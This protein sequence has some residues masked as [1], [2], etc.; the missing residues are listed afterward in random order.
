MLHL[1][2]EITGDGLD[3]LGQFPKQAQFAAVRALTATAK[4]A[5]LALRA[6]VPGVFHL[7]NSWVPQGV[8][9][10]P[11]TMGS[12]SARVGSIDKYMGRHVFGDPKPAAKPLTI[13]GKRSADG[14][15]ASGGL[16]IAPYSGIGSAEKHQVVRRRLGRI[17]RQKKKT[18]QILGRGAG[19]VLIV[20]RKGKKSNPLEV[21]AVLDSLVAER[22]IW[23]MDRTVSGVVGARFGDHFSAAV[24]RI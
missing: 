19:K 20:R 2:I 8:R 23:R 9:I 12:M 17:D 24:A 15:L 21:V 16:L 22:P 6:E 1:R 13:R 18:F 3:K 10:D 11:A 7:R 14:R 4:D 5:Q